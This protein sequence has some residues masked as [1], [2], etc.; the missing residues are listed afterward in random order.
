MTQTK[1]HVDPEF[2]NWTIGRFLSGKGITLRGRKKV[3]VIPASVVD[4][5]ADGALIL[6]EEGKGSY[7]DDNSRPLNEYVLVSAGFTLRTAKELDLLINAV[8]AQIGKTINA[9]K[10]NEPQLIT[11]KETANHDYN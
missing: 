11:H 6:V 3:F 8:K 5:M 10:A 9:Q 1:M 4:D 2:L 7:I